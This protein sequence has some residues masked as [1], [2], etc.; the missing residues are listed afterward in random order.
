MTRVALDT[1]VLVY[2]AGI[3]KVSEDHAKIART[4]ALL[5]GISRSATLVIPVQALGEMFVV[6]RRIG[7]PADK[8]R[9]AVLEMAGE[10]DTPPSEARTLFSALD[11]AVDHKLQH[12]DAM[13]LSAAADAGCTMLLSEDMQHGFVVRGVTVINPFAADIH[14]KLAALLA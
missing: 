6:M 8:C 10:L 7:Y 1:N 11:L 2:I 12:W 14:P 5:A 3:A 4:H 13:I 9:A